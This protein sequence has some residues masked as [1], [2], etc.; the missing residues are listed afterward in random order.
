MKE[1]LP[2]RRLGSDTRLVAALVLG[3]F[4]VFVVVRLLERSTD[5]LE[6]DIT[7]G[8]LLFVLSYLNITLITAILFV[9]GR[10]L[11]KTWLE[12]RRGRLGSRFGTKLLATYIALTVIPIAMI[13]F[14][15]T[16]RLDRTID[17]W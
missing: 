15:A 2:R 17:R 6:V 8:V 7:P 14:L 11:L 13:F 1:Q 12:R 9:L 5:Q 3:V 10:T 4:V 16:S